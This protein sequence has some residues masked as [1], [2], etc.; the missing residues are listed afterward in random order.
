MNQKQSCMN[1]PKNGGKVFGEEIDEKDLKWSIMPAME[2]FRI[3][4]IGNCDGN[5]QKAHNKQNRIWY[6]QK[7]NLLEKEQYQEQKTSK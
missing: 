4:D 7:S 6:S 3:Q 1:E 2:S 5:W